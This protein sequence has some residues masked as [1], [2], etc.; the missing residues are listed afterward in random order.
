METPAPPASYLRKTVGENPVITGATMLALAVIITIL[1]IW[2]IILGSKYADC[3][4]NKNSFR[5]RHGN[6]FQG[7][8]N[9]GTC[10]ASWDPAATAEAQALAQASSLQHDN[11]G[12]RRLQRSISGA[13]DTSVG[14]T[15]SQL[16]YAART[17]AP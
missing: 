10:G 13:Y 4:K 7:Y 1:I 6:A 17:G 5:A 3:K 8:P 12:E 9:T 14:L 16:A 15:D 2:L 11:Y